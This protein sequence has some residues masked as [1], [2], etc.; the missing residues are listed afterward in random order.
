MKTFF[1]C[2]CQ[3]KTGDQHL[4]QR[5]D[6]IFNLLPSCCPRCC[7]NRWK[8][9]HLIVTTPI[10]IHRASEYH[11]GPAAMF[12]SPRKSS[13]AAP[14]NFSSKCGAGLGPGA[15]HAPSRGVITARSRGHVTRD[16]W[17]GHRHT[18]SSSWIRTFTNSHFRVSGR[19]KI[20]DIIDIG[21]RYFAMLNVS[22][23]KNLAS[24]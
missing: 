16:T 20:I 3:L 6:Y 24:R 15:G 2:C 9:H 17:G 7:T 1:K 23:L 8:H 5:H 10:I 14:C 21:N 12:G 19:R 11:Y 13:S 22:K 4:H 18:D